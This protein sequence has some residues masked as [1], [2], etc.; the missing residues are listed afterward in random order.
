MVLQT[1]LLISSAAYAWGP[2]GHAIVADIA[3]AH[4]S[5]AALSE[6]KNLLALEGHENL[7]EIS[8]WADQTPPK[9]PANALWHYVD[10]P[11]HEPHYQADRDC[12][13]DAC[14]VKKLGE[15]ALL[16]ADKS[17]DKQSRLEALKWLT[18]FTG[19]IHQPLH[20]ENNADQGGNQVKL[21]YFGKH[22]NL[23]SIWDGA[24]LEQALNLRLGPNFTF[25]HA[26]VRQT[27]NQLNGMIKE[28]E[29]ESW[30]RPD[31]LNAIDNSAGAWAEESH[32]LA[33]V[34][35]DNLP[36]IQTVDGE[37]KYQSV[38]WPVA[39]TQLQKAGIRLAELLNEALR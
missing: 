6:V 31:L 13:R 22:T 25:D 30:S 17:K 24:I 26:L 3:E 27:A 12:Q 23:H 33:L 7:D 38:V 18:H 4:L 9:T 10:I 2:E 32:T 20:A 19:D 1:G 36:A 29:L 21:S 15:Y 37:A 11:L 34:A 16:L 28:S 39:R 14:V 35:Y 8:S 5:A